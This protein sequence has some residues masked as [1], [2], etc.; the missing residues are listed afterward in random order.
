MKLA[1]VLTLRLTLGILTLA[2]SALG[3]TADTSAPLAPG[4]PSGVHTAQFERGTGMYIVAGAALIGITVALASAGNGTSANSTGA[5][6]GGSS[7][8]TSTTGTSP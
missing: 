3:A 5:A 4:R 1:T 6:G 7:S 8:S 2:S